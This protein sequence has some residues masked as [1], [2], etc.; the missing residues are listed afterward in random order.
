M[1]IKRASRTALVNVVSVRRTKLANVEA[2]NL[3]A[4]GFTSRKG[5]L[6]SLRRKRKRIDLHDQITL[7]E[8]VLLQ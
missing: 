3:R 1:V 2:S 4:A 5:A 7:L 8:T 6:K